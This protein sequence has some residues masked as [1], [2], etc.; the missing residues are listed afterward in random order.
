M[1]SSETLREYSL[2]VSPRLVALT[3]VF[4]AWATIQSALWLWG[5]LGSGGLASPFLCLPVAWIGTGVCTLGLRRAWLPGGRA[6]VRLLEG[7][8]EVPGVDGPLA[9]SYDG[10]QISVGQG[11]GTFLERHVLTIESEEAWR[12]LPQGL[13][14]D[15]AHLHALAADLR[16]LARGLPLPA[17]DDFPD[18]PPP[19]D[20]WDDALEDELSR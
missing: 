5:A 1:P 3:V 7:G 10:L 18:G 20:A 11:S 9:L 12:S 4:G 8:V 17:H 6:A 19:R 16:A 13:F 14:A 15:P 2:R